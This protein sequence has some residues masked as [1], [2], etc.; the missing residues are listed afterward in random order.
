MKV[1]VGILIILGIS[2]VGARKSFTSIRFPFVVD[3]FFLTGT[4]FILV[5]LC[6]GHNFLN[7]LDEKSLASLAP[8][9]SLVLGWIGLL[10]G[11]QVE[12]RKLRRFPPSH[13][14]TTLVQSF[15]TMFLVFVVFHEILRRMHP[16]GSL[17]VLAA[18]W[19]LALTAGTT[20]QSVLVLVVEQMGRRRGKLIDLMRYMSS[21]DGVIGLVL[22]GILFC[23]AH[24]LTPGE[25]GVAGFWQWLA[26]TF[27]LGL[28]TGFLFNSLVFVKLSDQELLLVVIGMVTFSGG[29]ATCFGLSPL[30]VCMVMGIVI[31]NLS[32]A[33]ERVIATLA[34]GEKPVYLILLALAGAIWRIADPVFFLLAGLYWSVRLVGKLM[35]GYVAVHG[36]TGIQSPRA[37]G[38]GLLSQGGVAI[39]MILN[40]KQAYASSLTSGVVTIVLLSVMANEVVS[41]YLAKRVLVGGLES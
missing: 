15:V 25:L 29:I 27:G 40:F 21:L 38:L 8:F 16:G 17:H 22:F 39:A 7:V 20:A 32:P 12:F 5:G 37:V 41:P 18:S 30:L 24:P 36:F 2:L 28:I 11:M 9:L 23:Y 13:W 10:F 19:V 6:L 33:R 14:K 3:S 35:G 31:V 26:I 4:E 1:I 34:H